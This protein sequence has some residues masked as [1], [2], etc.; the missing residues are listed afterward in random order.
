MLEKRRETRYLSIESYAK[1]QKN[2]SGY[3]ASPYTALLSHL[4][5][6]LQHPRYPI[7]VAPLIFLNTYNSVILAWNQIPLIVALHEDAGEGADASDAEGGMWL[8]ELILF[9]KLNLPFSAHRS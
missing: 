3:V 1:N 2:S 8:K 6:L 5:T 4:P 7:Y 9:P